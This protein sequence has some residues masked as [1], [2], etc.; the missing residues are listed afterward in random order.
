MTM[1]PSLT[2]WM[3]RHCK[4]HSF[5][6]GKYFNSLKIEF[7]KKRMGEVYFIRE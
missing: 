4:C 2:D 5:Q 3:L 7:I 1:I 6:H